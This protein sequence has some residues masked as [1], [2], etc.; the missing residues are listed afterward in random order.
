[1]SARLGRNFVY[2]WRLR[3]WFVRVFLF[4]LSK[5]AIRQEQKNVAQDGLRSPPKT[6]CVII[7]R[8]II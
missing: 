3:C 4:K 6:L 1:M 2:F 5:Y 8:G 7:L